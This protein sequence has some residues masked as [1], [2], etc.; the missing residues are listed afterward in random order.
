MS[1][2]SEVDILNLEKI[3][4]KLNRP[5]HLFGEICYK[6]GNKFLD[7]NSSKLI[8]KGFVNN[9]EEYYSNPENVFLIPRYN[10]IGIPIKFLQLIKFRSK[11]ILFGNTVSFGMPTHLVENFL[12]KENQILSVEEFI[13][14][15]NY[16]KS[17][18]NISRFIKSNN[19]Q[20][21]IKLLENTLC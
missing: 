15:I 10:G 13:N 6:L 8:L 4:Q 16:E 12:Y 3:L 9:L 2:G 19:N 1:S 5:I 7:L 14:N 11:V 18:N 20:N 17:Y 21:R